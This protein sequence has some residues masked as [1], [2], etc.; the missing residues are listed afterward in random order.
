[1]SYTALK[2]FKCP[3][4]PRVSRNYYY[5]EG[6]INN[7]QLSP[8]FI[9]GFADAESSFSFSIV[10]TD[11]YKAGWY[12]RPSFQIELSDKDIPLLES[13][14][15]FMGVGN[16][17]IS[18][19]GTASYSVRNI[20]DLTNVIIPFF[21]KYNLITQ[22]Q[23]DFELFK[24]IINLINNKK[25]LTEEGFNEII[26]IRA[27][28]N[29]G[30]SPKLLEYFPNITPVNRPEVKAPKIQDANWLAGFT[31]GEGYFRVKVYKSTS[32]L[33]ESV[34]L[35]LVITQHARDTDL[36]KGLIQFMGCGAIMEITTKPVV[37]FYISKFSDIFN[38]IIPFYK[39]YPIQGSKNLDF[40]D[41]C[42][43]AELINAANP[44][45]SFH[46]I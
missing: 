15:S 32:K 11:E 42:K 39:K 20:K 10:K 34:Q 21:D 17:V 14:R 9:A 35:E 8:Y 13:I 26:S 22:K 28:L 19:R 31:A 16:I 7:H 12:I 24:Q 25:H 46:F 6:K 2:T 37:R 43:V 18:K 23:A 33:G 41:F 1:M 38:V 40:V 44:I 30:L 3:P 36:M 29:N 45:P 5:V 4:S 27:S